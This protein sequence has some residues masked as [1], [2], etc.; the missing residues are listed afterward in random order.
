MLA[1]AIQSQPST[2]FAQQLY[3]VKIDSVLSQCE[4]VNLL[5][6]L[7]SITAIYASLYLIL[8]S[9]MWQR[10]GVFGYDIHATAMAAG[11]QPGPTLREAAIHVTPICHCEDHVDK[12]AEADGCES[13]RVDHDDQ[14][15]VI[16][17]PPSFTDPTGQIRIGHGSRAPPTKAVWSRPS[18]SGVFLI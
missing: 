12:T 18:L 1:F 4:L 2:I 3:Q 15:F 6:A 11:S 7:K 10:L 9:C 5:I 14:S 13:A 17:D 16:I 8:P